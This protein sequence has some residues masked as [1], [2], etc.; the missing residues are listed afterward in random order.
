M[1]GRLAWRFDD[2]D[3]THNLKAGYLLGV[4]P[5]G[6]PLGGGVEHPAVDAGDGFGGDSGSSV[7]NS[8]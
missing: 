8:R 2:D 7:R 5:S 3:R 1:V 4:V 6:S